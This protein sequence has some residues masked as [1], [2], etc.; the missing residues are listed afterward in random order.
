MPGLDAEA[1]ALIVVFHHVLADGM[2]G[3]AILANIV[4][5]AAS[6]S[7]T[8][9]PRPQPSRRQLAVDAATWRIRSLG[10]IVRVPTFTVVVGN[11]TVA[12]A[13]ISYA[14]TLKVTVTIDR[15]AFPDFDVLIDSLQQPV[16]HLHGLWLNPTP[17][18][19]ATL[20]ASA[21]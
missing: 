7:T 17:D 13:V 2:G 12:F 3:L 1:C 15:D 19:A 16:R 10:R 11:V 20:R 18:S 6:A 21:I 4:D 5:A 8:N 14:G 9:F